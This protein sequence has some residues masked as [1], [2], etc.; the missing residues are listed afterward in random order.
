MKKFF[1]IIFCLFTASFS[2]AQMVN[3]ASYYG[4]ESSGLYQLAE[5]RFGNLYGVLTIHGSS[6]GQTEYMNSFITQDAFYAY[7][8]D[9]DSM[10]FKLSPDGE[11]LWSSYFPGGIANISLT[12]DGQSFYLSGVASPS[13]ALIASD[14]AP[15]PN[16]FEFGTES[17]QILDGFLMKFDAN[18][19]KVWEL[20]F[21]TLLTQP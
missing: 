9:A 20:I 3:W 18:G 13:T 1:H 19:Q 8:D 21:H 7:H 11:V 12:S 16:P 10:F 5:D 15:F 4:P 14:N 17:S 2:M 6:Y